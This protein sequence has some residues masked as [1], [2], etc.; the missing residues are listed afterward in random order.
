[1]ASIYGLYIVTTT[2]TIYIVNFMNH[3]TTL[4]D[5]LSR[6]GPDQTPAA[7]HP[8]S[9]RNNI[10][11]LSQS[12]GLLQLEMMPILEGTS[13]PLRCSSFLLDKEMCM[14]LGI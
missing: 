3:C 8:G 4:E 14:P 9:L 5:A 10:E 13:K 11:V 6:D 2:T 1:M 12:K 7:K